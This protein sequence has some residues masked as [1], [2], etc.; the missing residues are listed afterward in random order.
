MSRLPCKNCFARGAGTDRILV[1]EFTDNWDKID[2]A[3]GGK[4]GRVEKIGVVQNKIGTTWSS[5]DLS[6]IDWGSYQSVILSAPDL[7]D[8]A[9]E[10]SFSVNTKTGSVSYTSSEGSRFGKVKAAP[11]FLIFL[12][13]GDSSRTIKMI[14]IGG[15]AGVAMATCTYDN[16]KELVPSYSKSGYHYFSAAHD[17]ELWGVR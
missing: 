5:I 8:A 4:L 14:Y 12:P 15:F 11:Y 9:Y 17:Y 3:L 13:L 10:F 2:A 16:F 1:E 6:G 7:A